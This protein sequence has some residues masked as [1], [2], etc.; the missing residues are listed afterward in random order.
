[1]KLAEL[2]KRLDISLPPD[3]SAKRHDYLYGDGK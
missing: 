1:M 3:A 2:G